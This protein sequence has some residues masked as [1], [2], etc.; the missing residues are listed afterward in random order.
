MEKPVIKFELIE[1]GYLPRQAKPGD[2][3]HDVRACLRADE[4]N[5]KYMAHQE[6]VREFVRTL[7]ASRF[8]WKHL[9]PTY[10]DGERVNLIN[11]EKNLGWLDALA[12]EKKVIALAPKSANWTEGFFA[13]DLPNWFLIPLGFKVQLPNTSELGP[14]TYVMDIVSRSGIGTK[15]GLVIK[16]GEGTIDSGYR[17]EVKAPLENRGTELHFLTKGARIAQAKIYPCVSLSNYDEKELIV[18]QV[19]VSERGTGGFGHS[20]T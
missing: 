7:Q 1:E 11:M 5:D 18:D 16:Q 10:I 15:H 14:F 12:C 9:P 13:A 19:E 6:E 2:A 17:D 8:L 20:G 4:K 3:G